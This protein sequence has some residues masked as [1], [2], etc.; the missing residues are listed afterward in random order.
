[1]GLGWF[2][3]AMDSTMTKELVIKALKASLAKTPSQSWSHTSF[4]PG[5]TV[6]KP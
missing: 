3:V 2:S 1:M 4:R 5:R 6:R